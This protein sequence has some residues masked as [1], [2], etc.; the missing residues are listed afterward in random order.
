MAA[1]CGN[2]EITEATEFTEGRMR[3][4]IRD[5]RRKLLRASRRVL[6]DIARKG[7]KNAKGRGRVSITKEC[8]PRALVRPI[9]L[10]AL[11]VFARKTIKKPEVPKKIE[12]RAIYASQIFPHFFYS[13]P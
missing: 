13:S 12:N 4:D 7:A 1:I 10:C 9:I 11:R 8:R 5:R 2:T 3:K 6:G